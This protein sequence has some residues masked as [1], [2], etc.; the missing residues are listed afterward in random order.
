ML[1]W[2]GSVAVS[3]HGAR[4][5]ELALTRSTS[6]VGWVLVAVAGLL[7]PFAFNLSHFLALGPVLLGV[8]GLSVATMRRRL[9]FD[10]DD[11][12]LRVE[13]GV[14]G[15]R[16]RLAVP[17]FHLRR[18]V[19]TQERGQFVAYVERRTGGRIRIDESRRQERLL[20]MV[21]AICDATGLRLA[22]G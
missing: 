12:L 13:H 5:V 7:L 22:R 10:S 8:L 11:G 15:I 4:R 3:S 16:S 2:L 6:W 18:V 1:D 19:I 14:W 9:I 20:A 21:R 17:L